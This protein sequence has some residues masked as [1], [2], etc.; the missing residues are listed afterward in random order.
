MADRCSERVWK[1]DWRKGQCSHNASV[2]RDGKPYCTIHDPEYIKQKGVKRKARD[3]ANSC[4][5]CGYFFRYD[6]FGYCPLCGTKRVKNSS[7]Q[8][9]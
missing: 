5:K 2:V 8:V 3:D 1:D 6:H 4:P 9:Q 7:P